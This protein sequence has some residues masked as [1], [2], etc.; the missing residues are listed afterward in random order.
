[1]TTDDIICFMQDLV[2]AWREM[3]VLAIEREERIVW[4]E[5]ELEMHTNLPETKL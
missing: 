5:A 4:L 2:A 3:E 1:M